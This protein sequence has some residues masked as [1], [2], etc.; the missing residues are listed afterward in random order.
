MFPILLGLYMGLFSH[1]KEKT[2]VPEIP[3]QTL[4]RADNF[5]NSIGVVF[6]PISDISQQIVNKTTF[7]PF[8]KGRCTNGSKEL[9]ILFH[10][11]LIFHIF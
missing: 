8:V 3:P 9:L 10:I 4:G 6:T 7:A 11:F 2:Y 5:N 1:F